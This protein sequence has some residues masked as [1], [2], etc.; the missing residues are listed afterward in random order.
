MKMFHFLVVERINSEAYVYNCEKEAQD[1][2]ALFA[3]I[4]AKY[5]Q[6]RLESITILSEQE[7]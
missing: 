5:D 2:T 3:H 6:D 7:C 4:M 1:R